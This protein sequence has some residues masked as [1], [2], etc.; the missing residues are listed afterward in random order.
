[1]W[2]DHGLETV[3]EVFARA[4][5]AASCTSRVTDVRELGMRVVNERG[6]LESVAALTH[7]NRKP[8]VRVVTRS[9]REV[10]A[11]SYTHLDVYK[12]Q[13]LGEHVERVGGDAQ[14]LDRPCLLYTSRCV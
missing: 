6:D 1:M 13:V 4:G 8:T 11:V 7:N 5:M 9:G 14:R 10:T 2:T 3:A 12:R